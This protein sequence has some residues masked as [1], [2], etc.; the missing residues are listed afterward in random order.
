MAHDRQEGVEIWSFDEMFYDV[1]N[2][3]RCHGVGSVG[4]DYTLF[5]RRGWHSK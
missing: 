2:V 1:V 4:T 5:A 3:S